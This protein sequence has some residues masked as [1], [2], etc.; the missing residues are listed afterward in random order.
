MFESTARAGFES[1]ACARGRTTARLIGLRA[2]RDDMLIVRAVNI[3][4]L[5]DR[6]GRALREGTGLRIGVSV[7]EPGS[8][9]RSEGEAVRVLDNRDEAGRG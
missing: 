5:G 9:P 8:I 3:Q 2:G 7:L 4:P 6:V 1:W